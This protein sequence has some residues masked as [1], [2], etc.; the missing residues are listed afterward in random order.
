[1]CEFLPSSSEDEQ[2]ATMC[3]FV[4][5]FVTKIITA[6]LLDIWVD[7]KWS[8]AGRGNRHL[9]TTSTPAPETTP[10][11]YV[12]ISSRLGGLRDKL[13]DVRWCWW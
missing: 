6:S 12:E 10:P 1:M 3:A 4:R 7:W 8:V 11:A 5:N 2:L 9:V 13:L